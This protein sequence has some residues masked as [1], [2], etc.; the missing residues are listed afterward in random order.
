MYFNEITRFMQV[1]VLNI[2]NKSTI[3]SNPKITNKNKNERYSDDLCSTHP[4]FSIQHVS[5]FF[6][7]SAF[8]VARVVLVGAAFL[9]TFVPN[10]DPFL[11]AA[12]L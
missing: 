1:T 4:S 3:L 2:K 5:H 7:P 10:V 11:F 9:I 12:P 6:I 8:V